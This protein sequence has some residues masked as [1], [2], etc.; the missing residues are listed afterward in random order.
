MSDVVIYTQSGCA[1]CE[2]VKKYFSMKDV[3]YEERDRDSHISEML[4]LGG[5]VTT[6]LVKTPKGISYGFRPMELSELI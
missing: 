6:P 4:E 1:P 3:Q 5:R 2:S